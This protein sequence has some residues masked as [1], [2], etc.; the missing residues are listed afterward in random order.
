MIFLVLQVFI[1][2]IA[3]FL[4]NLINDKASSVDNEKLGNLNNGMSS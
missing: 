4:F 3:V 1:E 2:L